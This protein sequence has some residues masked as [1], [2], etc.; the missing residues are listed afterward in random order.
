MRKVI[1]ISYI[2][3]NNDINENSILTLKFEQN[4]D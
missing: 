4:N 3:L 1:I 2:M